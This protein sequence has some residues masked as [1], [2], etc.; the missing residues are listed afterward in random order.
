[1][2]TP[3]P[4]PPAAPV[5]LLQD[6]RFSRLA[7][8]LVDAGERT[9]GVGE[10]L[11]GFSERLLQQG[12]PVTRTTTHIQS[13]HSERTGTGR[14]WRRDRPFEEQHFGFSA[15]LDDRYARSP[16]RKVH[17]TRGWLSLW[18]QRDG[19]D[20]NI[21]PD[22]K[23]EGVEHYLI[24]PLFFSDGSIQAASF[25]TDRPEGFPPED[26]ALLQS[27]MPLFSRMLELKTLRLTLGEILRIYV[28]REPGARILSGQVR[29]GDVTA[30]SAAML[31]VDLRGF[32]QLSNQLADVPLVELLNRYFDCFVPPVAENGGEVL[33]FIGDAVLAIFPQPGGEAPQR[34]PRLAA[35][36]A[37][38]EGLLRL[39]RL[40]AERPDE[41]PL[42]AG[43]ALHLGRVAFGNV[44]S[45]ER[46]DFTVIG[47]DV[48]LAS[49]LSQLNAR[50]DEALLISAA[51][52]RGLDRPLRPLGPFRLKG[53]DEKQRVFA[54]EDLAPRAAD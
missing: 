53:F 19:G 32:T 12:V 3:F 37:A 35:L 14:V 9:Q 7:G 5:S 15:M 27:L 44:G 39:D 21:V 2:D 23:A 26:Q 36:A 49:R 11:E 10:L 20:F 38:E 4:R 54:L 1:M 42:K 30:L 28:G 34:E 45:V 40:N 18:P 13:L 29:R 46:Q 25:A 47:R 41:K 24:G 50:T 33:K 43:V 22:L 31:V 16:I 52:A 6:P 17:D 8:W 48:N 51:F